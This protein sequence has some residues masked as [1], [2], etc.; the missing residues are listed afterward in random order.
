MIITSDS[1]AAEGLVG[2]GT[3]AMPVTLHLTPPD[4]RRIR[5]AASPAFETLA[6]IRVATGP[7]APGH[8]RRWLE[9]VRPRLDELDLRPIT[10]LQP[11]RGYTP[12]FLAPP[13]TGP[14]ASFDDE[15]ARIAATPPERV[16]AEIELSLRDTPGARATALGRRL[17]GEPNEVLRL[18]TRLVD[19]AWHALVAPVWPRVRALLDAD[20]AFQ[21]RRLAEG[22]LDRLFAE[23]HP[24]LRWNAAADVLTRELGDDEHRELAGEGLVLMPSAFKSDQVVVVADR[25]WQPTVIYPARG[26]GGLWEPPRGSA[27]AALGRLIGHTRAALLAELTEP[28][29]TTWLAHR[30]ALAPATVSEHLSVLNEARLVTK[31]RHRHEIRYRRTDLGTALLRPAR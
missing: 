7:Q 10:L 28:A 9:S 23:L 27:D 4:L 12:D 2:P 18:L 25:P 5:F 20:V 26:L 17:L 6:A 19:E 3:P 31:E 13:P 8:H 14:S 11:R 30:H 22:G 15:L 1:A 29:S 24:T 16:R 21:S